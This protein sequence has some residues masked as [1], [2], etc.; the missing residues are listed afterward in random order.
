MVQFGQRK[1]VGNKEYEYRR[2]ARGGNH[3]SWFLV[4]DKNTGLQDNTMFPYDDF[5]D[6]YSETGKKAL[7]FE[8]VIKPGSMSDEAAEELLDV[9]Y[10]MSEVIDNELVSVPS[11]EIQYSKMDE[12]AVIDYLT[13]GSNATQTYTSD[14]LMDHLDCRG[15]KAGDGKY[16]VSVDTR[17]MRRT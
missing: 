17:S 15:L 6:D 8:S 14:Q 1:V 11:M 3:G 10:S 7:D 5:H 16:F 4:N 2:D 9:F 12:E 13:D